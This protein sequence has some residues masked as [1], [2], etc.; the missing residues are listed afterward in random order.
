MAQYVMLALFVFVMK[1]VAPIYSPPA[2]AV[3][4]AQIM[5]EAGISRT[6]YLNLGADC[7]ALS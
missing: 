1:K 2:D 4:I 3:E 5:A 7:A 6:I